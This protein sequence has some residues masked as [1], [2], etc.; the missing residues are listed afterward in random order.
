MGDDHW[1]TDAKALADQQRKSLMCLIDEGLQLR[2]R[3][4]ANPASQAGIRLPVL[5]VV[6]MCG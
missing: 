3:A 2:L 4:S 1:F 5:S 6:F